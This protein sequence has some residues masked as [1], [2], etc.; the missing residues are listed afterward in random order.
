VLQSWGVATFALLD[1]K[2]HPPLQ[3]ADIWADV[4]RSVYDSWLA[5]GKPRF[6]RPEDKWAAHTVFMGLFDKKY[7]LY[8]IEKNLWKRKKQAT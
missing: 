2:G 1:D 4:A 5:K 6:V 8:T 3:V 7:I